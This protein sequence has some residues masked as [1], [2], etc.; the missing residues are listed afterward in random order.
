MEQTQDVQFNFPKNNSNYIKVIG[1]GG[2]GG[3]AVNF[4]YD[5]GINGVD[6]LICNTDAQALESSNIPNKIQLGVTLT[7]GLGAGNNPE[8]GEKA[9]IESENNI[10][11]ALEGNTQM[12][13]ITAGMGGGTGTGAVPII[14][15]KAKEMGILT[16]AIVTTP[17]NF[18]GL[19]RSRQAQAG[20]KKLRDSVDSLIV[21]NNNKIN[22]MYGELSIS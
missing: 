20:I 5:N 15:K 17:F 10:Q 16:V 7:E 18:E 2:G 8:I 1:V 11:K 9:A 6:Y 14:A 19:K 4:M 3:N 22:E 13:F 21:I 12:I